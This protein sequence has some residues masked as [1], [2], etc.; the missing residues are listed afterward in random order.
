MIL[1]FASVLLLACNGMVDD[2]KLKESVEAAIKTAYP[3]VVVEMDNGIVILSGHVQDSRAK[4][5][6]GKL[7]KSVKGVSE[8]ENNVDVAVATTVSP[9]E[10]LTNNVRSVIKDYE[11][12]NAIVSDSTVI[13]SGKLKQSKL[14]ELVTKVEAFHPKKVVTKNIVVE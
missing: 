12:I 6:L 11:G 8:I 9:N 5:N 13:L 2:S 4:E 1:F 10:G 3:G 14:E 7:V